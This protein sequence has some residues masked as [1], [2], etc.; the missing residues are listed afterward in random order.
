MV[1]QHFHRDLAIIVT[2]IER[3]SYLFE[4]ETGEQG[5]KSTQSPPRRVIIALDL[6]VSAEHK[7]QTF[8]RRTQDRQDL[9]NLPCPAQ[10]IQSIPGL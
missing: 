8:A 9:A 3:Y 6:G 2:D 10:Q 4:K 1:R 5:P 7:S